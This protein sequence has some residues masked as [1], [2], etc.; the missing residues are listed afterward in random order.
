MPDRPSK[1][2]KDLPIEKRVAAAEAFWLDDQ[3]QD[4]VAQHVEAI[5]VIAQRLKFRP[6][7]VQALPIERRAR[8]LAQIGD[9]SDAIA[10]RA[11]IAYH[12]KDAR[13][14]M[15]AFL[16]G[17]G[18]AHDNGLITADEVKPP[19]EAQ[20]RSAVETVRKSFPVS[21]LET[22]LRT[23]SAIDGDTWAAVDKVLPLEP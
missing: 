6:K 13:P 5:V 2:W 17:V 10:T 3:A 15:S 22:Y 1:I 21:D 12:F 14:L 11:L 19:E 16:D 23:L 20:V 8:Q 9:V 18:I 7:S 4:I